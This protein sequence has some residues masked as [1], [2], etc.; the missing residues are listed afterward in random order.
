MI[1]FIFSTFK[2]EKCLKKGKNKVAYGYILNKGEDAYCVL[3]V[4]VYHRGEVVKAVA[5]RT[6]DKVASGSMIPFEID[7]NLPNDV[8]ELTFIIAVGGSKNIPNSIRDVTF[9]D[10][11]EF[12]IH[13]CSGKISTNILLPVGVVIAAAGVLYYVIKKVR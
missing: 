3:F 8:D 1:N 7:I 10:R 9:T 2:V 13:M 5:F 6:K 11:K 12:T 4:G